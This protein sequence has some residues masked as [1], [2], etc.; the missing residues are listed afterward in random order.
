ML[1]AVEPSTETVIPFAHKPSTATKTMLRATVEL[2]LKI[3]PDSRG[4]E[5]DIVTDEWSAVT[6]FVLKYF[7]H[8]WSASGVIVMPKSAAHE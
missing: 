3:A 1:V 4:A 6:E 2:V 8:I 5:D 7:P